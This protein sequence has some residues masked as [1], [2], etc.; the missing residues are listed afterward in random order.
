MLADGLDESEV[1]PYVRSNEYYQIYYDEIAFK[2]S[3]KT[4]LL[5]P[6]IDL[7]LMTQRSPTRLRD[8][9]FYLRA[10]LEIS[11]HLRFIIIGASSYGILS[12]RDFV[13]FFIAAHPTE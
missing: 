11:F 4:S 3:E 9:I 8:S 7:I 12:S 6:V 2:I 1:Q 10:I 5:T 13:S